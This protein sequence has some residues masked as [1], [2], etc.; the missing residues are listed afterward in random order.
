ML[1]STEITA[2][3]IDLR[4]ESQ[5]L[6]LLNISH[7]HSFSMSA[8]FLFKILNPFFIKSMTSLYDL[9][10]REG[11]FLFG[12]LL[13]VRVFPNGVRFKMILSIE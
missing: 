7:H 13:F 10:L 1:R 3:R 6:L 11:S 8:F 5:V 4:F 9:V 2:D 12:H